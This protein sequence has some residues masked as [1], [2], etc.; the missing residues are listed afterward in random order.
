MAVTD[1][2]LKAIL[3]VLKADTGGGFPGTSVQ[4]AL[5]DQREAR[6]QEL[7]KKWDVLPAMSNVGERTEKHRKIVAELKRLEAQDELYIY[8]KQQAYSVTMYAYGK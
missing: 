6:R 7:L 1:P 2:R 8:D 4:E 5:H 3:E